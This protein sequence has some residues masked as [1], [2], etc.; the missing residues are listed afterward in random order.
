VESS[1]SYEF[2]DKLRG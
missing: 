2:K 1:E